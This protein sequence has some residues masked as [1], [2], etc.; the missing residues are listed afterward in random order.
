M[1]LGAERVDW[2]DFCRL[3]AWPSPEGK[4]ACLVTDD[5]GGM[6][7]LLADNVEDTQIETARQVLTLSRQMLGNEDAASRAA[8]TPSSRVGCRSAC[9][10]CC[11]SPTRAARV[12]MEATHR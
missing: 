6:L 1:S 4:A 11:A 10:T 3:L 12:S 9:T 2:D 8:S 5:P 7:S